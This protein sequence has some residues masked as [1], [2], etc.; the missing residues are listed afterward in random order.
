MN[1]L[2]GLFALLGGSN[3]EILFIYRFVSTR[4]LQQQVASNT[5]ED[6]VS[7]SINQSEYQ[8]LLLSLLET[9]KRMVWNLVHIAV[10]YIISSTTLRFATQLLYIQLEVER[11]LPKHI[12]HH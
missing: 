12:N 6:N 2:E 3:L 9:I 1:L 10:S 4:Q 8:H 7:S 11:I 5:D